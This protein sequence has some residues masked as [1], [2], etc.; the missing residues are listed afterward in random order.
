[1]IPEQVFG[2]HVREIVVHT[3]LAAGTI[4]GLLGLAN[5]IRGNLKKDRTRK[6]RGRTQFYAG[7]LFTA[8]YLFA[9]RFPL[10]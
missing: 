8:V 5:L 2:L 7:M 3:S 1:M 4:L 10:I 9:T 6:N